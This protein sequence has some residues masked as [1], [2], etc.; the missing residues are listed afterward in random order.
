MNF[1]FPIDENLRLSNNF[2]IGY[3]KNYINA[4]VHEGKIKKAAYEL[5]LISNKSN[6]PTIFTLY[7]NGA[8]NLERCNNLEGLDLYSQ[9]KMRLAK[10]H[11]RIF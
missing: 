10:Y 7:W 1:K 5:K 4:L 9:N 11:F 3:F 8:I 2:S 6:W